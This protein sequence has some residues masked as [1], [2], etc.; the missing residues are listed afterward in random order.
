M[1]LSNIFSMSNRSMDMND[2]YP[3]TYL[4]DKEMKKQIEAEL[5]LEEALMSHE[6]LLNISNYLEVSAN[7]LYIPKTQ[8]FD[9]YY[10]MDKDLGILVSLF[11]GEKNTLKK[12][13]VKE[14]IE[15]QKDYIK[16]F[17]K[18][19]DFDSYFSFIDSKIR[20]MMLNNMFNRIPDSQKYSVFQLVYS[21]A[22]Y[23]FDKINKNILKEVKRHI[24][25]E[26]KETL[27][28]YANED[29]TVTI[30]RGEAEKS[31]KLKEAISWTT[32]LET[33]LYFSRRF[34]NLN[35]AIYKAK[36]SPDNIIAYIDSR[37]EDEILVPFDYLDSVS[38]MKLL[39]LSELGD[40]HPDIFIKYNSLKSRIDPSLFF[41]ANGIHGDFHA[42]RVLFLVLSLSKLEDLAPKEEDLLVQSAIYHD[43][44]RVFD[45][46][47]YE[48]GIKSYEIIEENNFLNGYSLEDKE[49]IR[50]I[51][52]N[53][54]IND[55]NFIPIDRYNIKNKNR[56]I[57]LLNIFK[58]ADGLDRLRINDL[59]TDFLR[60]TS[61]KDLIVVASQLIQFNM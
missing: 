57:N 5:K 32:K 4:K 8:L 14:Q 26:T 40:L 38:N 18:V 59:D 21:S 15:F 27:L 44:G 54:C 46:I 23:G 6:E 61:A 1:N 20:I 51:I 42:K 55:N 25:T 7:D 34:S 47:C 53:H 30:Y 17:L 10:Y 58:D 24:P 35:P 48:H 49:T 36:V 31:T 60:T 13:R 33:A 45:D 37:G 2:L 3:A 9:M 11:D 12:F 43:I 22:E 50:Y 52:E 39:N 56:A 16:N 28:N 29:G 19:S 41:D